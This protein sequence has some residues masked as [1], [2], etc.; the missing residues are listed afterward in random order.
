M[1]TDSSAT[2]THLG[3]NDPAQWCPSPATETHMWWG[4]YSVNT[5]KDPCPRCLA[6]NDSDCCGDEGQRVRIEK[7]SHMM[8]GIVVEKACMVCNWKWIL[9]VAEE[10]D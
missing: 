10:A 3:S 5:K 4:Q 9:R 1:S 6:C 8:Y 2:A 7:V